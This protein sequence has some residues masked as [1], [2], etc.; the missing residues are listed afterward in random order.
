MSFSYVLSL[1]KMTKSC[2]QFPPL[3]NE[4]ECEED[5]VTDQLWAKQRQPERRPLRIQN[6]NTNDERNI[7]NKTHLINDG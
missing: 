3:E 6:Q 1:Y 5:E 4:L 7:F 2:L